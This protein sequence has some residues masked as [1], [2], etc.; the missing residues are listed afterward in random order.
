MVFIFSLRKIPPIREF[1]FKLHDRS[2]E[3]PAF[4]SSVRFELEDVCTAVGFSVEF[5]SSSVVVR[6]A[7]QQEM[8]YSS[9]HQHLESDFLSPL[10]VHT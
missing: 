4:F 2:T 7:E 10:C 8:G 6:T 5:P 1:I 3:V 9:R